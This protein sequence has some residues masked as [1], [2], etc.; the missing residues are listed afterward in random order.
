MPI[1]QIATHKS[2]ASIAD[3]G[4]GELLTFK[5]DGKHL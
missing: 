2:H 3:C 1:Y 5:H 4:N